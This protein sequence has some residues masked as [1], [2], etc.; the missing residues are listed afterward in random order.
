MGF[1]VP[2]LGLTQ[3]CHREET[4]GKILKQSIEDGLLVMAWFLFTGGVLSYL[5]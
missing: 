1:L 5:Q 4:H 2:A 3:H